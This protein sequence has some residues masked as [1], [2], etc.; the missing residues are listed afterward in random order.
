MHSGIALTFHGNRPDLCACNCMS[1]VK[2]LRSHS[3]IYTHVYLSALL[4]K[5][6]VLKVLNLSALLINGGNLLVIIIMI[7]LYT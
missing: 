6:I 3:W 4:K 2:F 1:K 7:M 5:H